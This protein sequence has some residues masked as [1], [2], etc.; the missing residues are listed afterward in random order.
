MT[1]H[2]LLECL[3]WFASRA[4]RQG[5]ARRGRPGTT[6]F[7]FLLLVEVIIYLYILSIEP[8]TWRA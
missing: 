7:Y 4:A 1:T 2:D 6:L 5:Q 8:E 3:S